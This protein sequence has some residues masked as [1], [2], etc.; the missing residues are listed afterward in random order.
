VVSWAGVREPKRDEPYR[1]PPIDRGHAGGEPRLRPIAIVTGV[2]VDWFATLAASFV[3]ATMA[4][5]V[6]ASRYDDPVRMKSYVEELS[7]APDF[8]VLST[9]L[10]LICVALGGFAAGWLA[11]RAELRHAIAMGFV[12]LAI[13]ISMDAATDG[14]EWYPEWLRIGGHVLVLPAAMLGGA[15]SARVREAPKEDASLN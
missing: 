5:A 7:R 6:A 15:V 4:S 9:A 1:P 13:G 8:L 2:A 12:S 10:G 11:P 3:V 14:A